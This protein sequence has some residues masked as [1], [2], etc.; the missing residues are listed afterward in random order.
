V[1]NSYAAERVFLVEAKSHIPELIS[2]I[3]AK[4]PKSIKIICDS[5][6]KTKRQLGSKTNFDW[7]KTFN[8]YANR[9]AHVNF[10]RGLYIP[11]YLVCV[12]FVNDLEMKEPTSVDEWKGAIRLLH[13]CLGLRDHF[14]QKWIVDV[15][16]QAMSALEKPARM[17]S[18]QVS[19]VR[20]FLISVYQKA[21]IPE[22]LWKGLPVHIWR[23]TSAQDL[24]FATHYNYELAAQI[25]GWESTEVMKKSYG[26]IPDEE[27]A[28]GL[29]GAM[30]LPVAKEKREFLFS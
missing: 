3:Q 25:L 30:G 11:A 19:H 10:L 20:A 1:R 8:Q 4:N 12:Y 29:R 13:R 17:L 21:G 24:L 15:F 27:C 5:L 28:I 26:K 18:F 6:E 2:S 7:S 22:K 14:L 23:H 16:R 9:L